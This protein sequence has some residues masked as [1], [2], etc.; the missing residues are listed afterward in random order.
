MP[1]LGQI[2]SALPITPP[3]L[4]PRKAVV[5]YPTDFS[6]MSGDDLTLLTARCE[7]LTRLAIEHHCPRI[8]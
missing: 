2:D 1:Y 5:A 3:D 6:P 7:Q 8:A 4:V